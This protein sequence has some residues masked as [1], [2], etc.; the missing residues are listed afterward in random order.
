MFYAKDNVLVYQYCYKN[1]SL[2]LPYDNKNPEKNNVAKD[3]VIKNS[4]S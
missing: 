3:S 4:G 2:H 1:I